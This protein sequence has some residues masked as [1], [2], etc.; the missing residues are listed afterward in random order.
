MIWDNYVDF[1]LA[2][3]VMHYLARNHQL[4]TLQTTQLT[5]VV[6]VTDSRIVSTAKM[7]KGK[8]YDWEEE[9]LL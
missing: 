8:L 2:Q 7:R 4:V 6:G 1:T 9:Y 3:N 5:N